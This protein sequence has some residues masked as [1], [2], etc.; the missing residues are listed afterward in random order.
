[1]AHQRG[2]QVLTPP[3]N[4]VDMARLIH[5]VIQYLERIEDRMGTAPGLRSLGAIY[6]VSLVRK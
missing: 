1:M 4:L 2:I 5:P 6:L 3:W